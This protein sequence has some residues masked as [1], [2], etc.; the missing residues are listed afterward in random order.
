MLCNNHPAISYVAW[1]G[2]VI[3]VK[4][5][6]IETKDDGSTTEVEV[7]TPYII[8]DGKS[9]MKYLYWDKTNP[10]VLKEDNV[11]VEESSSQKMIYINENGTAT[12]VPHSDISLYYNDTGNGASAK[13]TGEALGKFDELNGKYMIVKEDVDGIKEVLGTEGTEEGGT[14][15]DRLNKVEKTAEKTTEE[16]STVRKD[17]ANSKELETLRNNLNIA[18]IDLGEKRYLTYCVRLSCDGGKTWV[19]TN[20]GDGYGNGGEYIVRNLNEKTEYVYEIAYAPRGEPF[21][22]GGLAEWHFRGTVQ[23]I[24]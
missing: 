22:D 12:E 8:S 23:V 9:C 7:E 4:E 2:L 18:M 13:L 14:L 16:I 11:W 3:M 21:D 5:K 6:R 15:I 1:Y 17:F 10:Y 19:F 24:P 20:G